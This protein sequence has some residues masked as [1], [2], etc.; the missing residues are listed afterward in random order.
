M[1]DFA[2]RAPERPGR[3]NPGGALGPAL[4]RA[5]PRGEILP[6][7]I[8][9]DHA[10]TRGISSRRVR[11]DRQGLAYDSTIYTDIIIAGNTAWNRVGGSTGHMYLQLGSF[12][13]DAIIYAWG[14]F[15]WANNDATTFTGRVVLVLYDFDGTDYNVVKRADNVFPEQRLPNDNGY[16]AFNGFTQF[17]LPADSGRDFWIGMQ[18]QNA[19]SVSHIAQSARDQQLM[20]FAVALDP[21][22][23]TNL[24]DDATLE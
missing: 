23:P 13:Y 3:R 10:D 16:V 11:F 12:A 5:T 21:E 20:A 7:V 8:T 1:G 18:A 15:A 19:G 22:Q 9:T 2:R 4:P 17:I 24:A 6:G 14:G